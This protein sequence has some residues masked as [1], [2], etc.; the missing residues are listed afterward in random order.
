MALEQELRRAEQARDRIGENLDDIEHRVAPGN[1]LRVAST[2]ARASARS[3]PVAWAI[4]A[5]VS[6]AVVVGVVTWA[7]ISDD[8]D[9]EG[10]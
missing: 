6:L 5:A 1:L 4:G 9:S 10:A 2:L 7:L 8:D 3:H